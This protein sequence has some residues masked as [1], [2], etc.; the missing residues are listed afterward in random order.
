MNLTTKTLAAAVILALA[1]SCGGAEPAP[2]ESVDDTQ[3][4]DTS[5][6]GGED[7]IP[8]PPTPWEEM[9]FED[10]KSWMALEVMP[11]VAPLFEAYDGERFAGFGCE[12]CHGEGAQDRNYEMPNSGIFTLH[13][14]GSQEQLHM[15]NEMRPMVNFMF[16]DVVPTMRTLLGEEEFDSESGEG[17]GCF[18]CHPNGGEGT[19]VEG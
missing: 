12:G 11:R 1:A 2:D 4:A 13:A 7:V 19:P 3:T 18:A 15:V 5:T 16:Q 14:S 8:S 9:S 10:K 17:F 6:A